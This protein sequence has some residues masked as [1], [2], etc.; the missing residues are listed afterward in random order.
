MDDTHEPLAAVRARRQNSITSM[1]HDIQKYQT[2]Q[3]KSFECIKHLD[4]LYVVK[5]NCKRR[6]QQTVNGMEAHEPISQTRLGRQQ[7][8]VFQ[9]SNYVAVSYTCARSQ[10]EDLNE[11]GYIVESR[12]GGNMETSKVRDC[13]FD[14][15]I[16][17]L[18]YVSLRL[19]WIDQESINQ[20]DEKEK[21]A[22]LEVMDLVYS[23]SKHP[24]ALLSKTINSIEDLDLL[25]QILRGELVKNQ[26]R[27]FEITPG[28]SQ[29]KAW[30]AVQ[31]LHTITSDL[32][33]TRA[34]TFQEENR[35]STK[36]TL[37]IPHGHLLETQKRYSRTLLGNA[38]GELCINSAKFRTEATK[39]CL[40]YQSQTEDQMT[41]RSFVLERAGEYNVLLQE[42]DI[43]G[44]DIIR[45]SMSPSIIAEIGAR[46]LLNPWDRLPIT[47]NCCRY[48]VRLDI[49][50][51]SGKGHS[52]S[53]SMLALCLLN[54][55]ILNNNDR[56]GD[57]T[58]LGEN[59]YGFLKQKAFGRFDPPVLQELSF[60]K[61]C[62]FLNVRLAADGIVTSGH[63]W[64]LGAIL[65]R[66]EFSDHL[67]FEP[68]APNGLD[69]HVRRRLRQL[70]QVTKARSYAFLADKLDAFLRNDSKRAKQGLFSKQYQDL[71]AEQVVAAIDE[72]KPL[73]LGVLA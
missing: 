33:W 58:I 1:L 65:Y 25:I 9:S 61:G 71:M 49:E 52:V 46:N 38:R 32:W 14:R 41:A 72:G 57:E 6:Y 2:L 26:A 34:W 30:K 45:R 3:A 50:A 37:M 66:A 22:A 48:S 36:M 12:T 53:I 17:Y 23:I 54:G 7:I 4:C 27:P 18:D 68:D 20:E 64:K 21:R 44:N 5:P 13:V 15:V 51:L 39:L 28:V 31:L 56:D 63:L 47:G 29:E 69:R 19:F 62:R 43:E 24:V 67:P 42:V 40:A 55:E 10:N 60:I 8:N 16:K 59:I 11:E 35:A 70:S 73:R